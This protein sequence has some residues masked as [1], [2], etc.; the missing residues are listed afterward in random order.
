MPVHDATFNAQPPKPI[1]VWC[2]KTTAITEGEPFC[3]NSDYGTA[4]TAEGR[5]S[6]EVETPSA[7]NNLFFAGVASKA[8]SACETGAGG[9]MITIFVPGSFC[10]IRAKVNCTVNVTRLTFGIGTSVDYFYTGGLPGE[11]TATALQ[12]VDRSSTEGLV[13]AKLEVGPPS[14]GSQI[15]TP[16]NGAMAGVITHGTVYFPVTTIGT[17]DATLTIA[18]GTFVGQRRVFICEGT[19]TTNNIVLTVTTHALIAAVAVAGYDVIT[20]DAAGE[21]WQGVWTPT[22][23]FGDGKDAA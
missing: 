16:A 15:V 21:G 1:R 22:G 9:Q 13:Y 4:A 3:Y 20:M 5:R 14:G 2:T 17:G 8:Y 23:W 7:S 11:G 19:M 18:D 10:N 6:F 12:T